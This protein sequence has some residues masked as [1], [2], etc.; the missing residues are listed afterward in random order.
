MAKCPTLV[1]PK[2][3][4]FTSSHTTIIANKLSAKLNINNKH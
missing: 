4:Q 1:K 2:T 3:L